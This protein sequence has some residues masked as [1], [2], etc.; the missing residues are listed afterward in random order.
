[1]PKGPRRRS[2]TK[3][4]SGREAFL[5]LG[6]PSLGLGLGVAMIQ[7]NFWVG[8]A[9][10]MI[11]LV[12]LW[13]L[14][15][16]V[17]TANQW[18][19]RVIGVIMSIIVSGVILWSIWI[20]IFIKT[21]ISSSPGYHAPGDDV[22]GIKWQEAYSEVTVII[23]NYGEADMLNVDFRIASDLLI[24]GAGIAPSINNCSSEAVS[25]NLANVRFS[26]TDKKR[27]ETREVPFLDKNRHFAS[28]LYRIRCERLSSNSIL[29]I[30][31]PMLTYHWSTG[32]PKRQPNWAKLW[33]DLMAGYR[34]VHEAIE[35]CFA[36]ACYSIPVNVSQVPLAVQ[37]PPQWILPQ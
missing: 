2:P 21:V 30:K 33:I 23:S 1:M 20:P 14:L 3:E 29:E 8:V 6:I 35:Q 28:S 4:T 19:K 26:L 24:A 18:I 16:R 10:M 22:N 37:S 11:S 25:P 12:L 13:W 32:E 15:W 7:I 5:V 27:G 36:A 31:L 17:F 9:L 34:P